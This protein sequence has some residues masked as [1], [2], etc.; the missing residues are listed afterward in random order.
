[1]NFAVIASL[2]SAAFFG[3]ATSLTA[4]PDGLTVVA[5]LQDQTALAGAH[6]IRMHAGLAY[7]AG[8][9]GSLAIVSVAQPSSPELLWSD[10]S[11]ETYADVQTVLPL[12]R[13]RLLVGARE[14][15]LFD[16]RQ[17]SMPA[18][19]ATLRDRPRIDQVNSF[20]RFGDTVY[21]ANSNGYIF[22]ADVSGT[23]RIRL[24][25][26]RAVRERDNLAGPHDVALS[27]DFLVVV[28]G[29]GFGRDTKR[30]RFGT[31]GVIDPVTRAALAPEQWGSP[32]I[33]TDR[34]FAGAHRV[35]TA[36]SFAYVGST[37]HVTIVDLSN[38]AKPRVRGT[39]VFSD[40]RGSS[41]LAV[42]GRIV[43]AAGG[44]TVQAIDV[45]N[46]GQPRELA[47]VSAPAAFSGGGDDAHDLAYHD[48]YLFITAQTSHALVVVRVDGKQL[49]EAARP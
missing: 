32:T 37:N 4:Q 20:A 46:P 19:L 18:L 16:V 10:Q 6:V 13:G 25:G 33:I 47:R 49:R 27:G 41:G 34:R 8:K 36:G 45:S 15:L 40:D 24:L 23:D 12:D 48:G 35:V 9:G 21:G 2:S 3:L 14:L 44:Q 30:G 7:I 22:S 11:A 29:D 43:F 5:V 39:I 26:T 31:Y 28:D 17:P 1:M 38:P 42:S